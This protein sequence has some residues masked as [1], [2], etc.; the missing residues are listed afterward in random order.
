LDPQ[1]P[2]G[3]CSIRRKVAGQKGS[4]VIPVTILS[5]R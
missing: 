4:S 2:I 1:I 3:G 5:K